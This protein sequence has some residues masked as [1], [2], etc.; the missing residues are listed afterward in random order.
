MKLTGPTVYFR[1]MD[2]ED[3]VLGQLAINGFHGPPAPMSV[4]SMY[5]WK[6]G[7]RPEAREYILDRPLE[8]GE[9]FWITLAIC[10]NDTDE[11]VGYNHTTFLDRRMHSGGTF[12]LPEHRNKGVYKEVIRLRHRLGFDV[13]GCSVSVLPIPVEGDSPIKHLLDEM[14]SE[15]VETFQRRNEYWRE[16]MMT[17]ESYEH[18][19]LDNPEVAQMQWSLDL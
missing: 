5:S 15:T 18:Y 16:A 1:P 9:R 14:Y 6:W 19:L 17:S 3:C 4:K 12:L 8:Y 2:P 11:F 13:L 7:L 10:L